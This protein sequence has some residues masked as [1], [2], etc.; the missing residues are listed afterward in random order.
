MSDRSKIDWNLF[1]GKFWKPE[2][3]SEHRVVLGNWGMQYSDFGGSE[4]EAKPVIVFDVLKIDGEEVVTDPLTF[5]TA[6]KEFAAKI[7]P[8]IKRAES[9]G[10]SAIS[11]ALRRTDKGNYEV[12]DLTPDSPKTTEE[13]VR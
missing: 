7:Q 10:R 11:V 9:A 4:P 13:A 12:F 2:K 5:S 8:I 6:S 3:G 1:K